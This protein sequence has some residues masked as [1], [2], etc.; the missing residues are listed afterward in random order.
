MTVDDFFGL[1]VIAIC[2]FQVYSAVT[3]EETTIPGSA[4]LDFSKAEQPVGYWI[5]LCAWC[6]FLIASIAI[7]WGRL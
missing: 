1:A 3:N 7:V 5:S 2:A 4:A 6:G